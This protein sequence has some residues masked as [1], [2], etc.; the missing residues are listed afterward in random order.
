M[1]SACHVKPSSGSDRVAID[2]KAEC[3]DTASFLAT[4]RPNLNAI[5]PAARDCSGGSGELEVQWAAF[6]C[7]AE[8]GDHG[9]I[10]FAGGGDIGA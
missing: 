4:R 1:A 6:G 7:R 5:S 2:I 8:R 10:A 9:V 3:G